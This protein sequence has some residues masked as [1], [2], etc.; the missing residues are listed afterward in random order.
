MERIGEIPVLEFFCLGNLSEGP[1]E[2]EVIIENIM[3]HVDK[4]KSRYTLWPDGVHL[5][6][7]RELEDEEDKW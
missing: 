2:T 3:T 5:G 1:A 6:V 7:P 4:M